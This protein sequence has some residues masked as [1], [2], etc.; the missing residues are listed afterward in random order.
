MDFGD[1]TETFR[2][3][4]HQEPETGHQSHNNVMDG[5]RGKVKGEETGE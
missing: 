2:A 3:G 5:L 4:S 1:G